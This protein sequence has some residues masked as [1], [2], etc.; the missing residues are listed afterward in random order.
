ML[1]AMWI[2][3]DENGGYRFYFLASETAKCAGG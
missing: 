3:D 1:I 2:A